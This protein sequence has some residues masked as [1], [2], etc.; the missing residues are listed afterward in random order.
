MTLEQGDQLRF[1]ISDLHA[2]IPVVYTGADQVPDLFGD[3][4]GTVLTGRYVDGVFE[5]E[6]ILTKHDE[7]Y[8]PAEVEDD[9]Q[10]VDQGGKHHNGSPV[11]VIVKYRDI[12]FLF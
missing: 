7:T 4:Q 12:Q 10:G 2:A 5:A 1:A 3:C 8:M 6:N 9:L 11:L